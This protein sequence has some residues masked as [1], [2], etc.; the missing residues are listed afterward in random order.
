[1]ELPS[2]ISDADFHIAQL[3]LILLTSVAKIHPMA[4][5]SSNNILPEII[6]LAKSPLLQ[7]KVSMFG[8]MM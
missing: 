2:L 1:M 5:A 7:G 3:T 6:T 4:L 8:M